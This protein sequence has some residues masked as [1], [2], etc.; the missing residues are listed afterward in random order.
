MTRLVY[1]YVSSNKNLKNNQFHH[2]SKNYGPNKL[3]SFE[4]NEKYFETINSIKKI[5][6]GTV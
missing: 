1:I 6:Q 2:N 3:A 5:H 4:F